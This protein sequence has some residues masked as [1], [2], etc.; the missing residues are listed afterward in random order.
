MSNDLEEIRY[1]DFEEQGAE[2]PFY[3][4]DGSAVPLVDC[5][6]CGKPTEADSPCSRCGASAR[7]RDVDESPRARRRAART[8][9]STAYRL[10]WFYGAFLA[11]SVA[12]GWVIHFG[13]DQKVINDVD[14][15]NNVLYQMIGLELVD[16]VLILVALVVVKRPAPAPHVDIG[17]RIAAWLAAPLFLAIALGA[18]LGYH[19]L[20]ISMTGLP[21][22]EDQIVA[23]C[24]F[25][26]PLIFAYCIQPAIFEELFFRHLTLGTLREV[27]GVH[28]AIFASSI[29]FGMCHIGVPLSIPILTVIGIV[30]GYARVLSGGLM[31]PITLHFAHNLLIPILT[32]S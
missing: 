11:T 9:S 17:R 4:N 8:E 22:V 32:H 18:N 21:T 7:P 3:L 26:A 25:T 29:M 5:W 28:G 16:V 31:L 10:L 30:L 13:L 6:R 23:K 24:G 14:T 15:A 12:F 1:D 2:A 27:T 20:L 19:H